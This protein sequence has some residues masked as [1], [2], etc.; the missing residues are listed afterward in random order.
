MF[1]YYWNKKNTDLLSKTPH[2]LTVDSLI[3]SECALGMPLLDTIHWLTESTY[4]QPTHAASISVALCLYF[5][6]GWGWSNIACDCERWLSLQVVAYVR[7][8]SRWAQAL[9]TLYTPA[10]P[11]NPRRCA[12]NCALHRSQVGL[13]TNVQSI[14]NNHM[15]HLK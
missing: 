2:E 10:G 12:P 14:L 6:C 15:S 11:R 13:R 1:V 4:S 7:L 5:L 3:K 8:Y 9:R